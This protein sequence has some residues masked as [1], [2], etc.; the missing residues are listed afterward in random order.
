MKNKGFTLTELIVT[1]VIGSIII[2]AIT[3]QF[4]AEYR[5]RRAIEERGDSSREA[6]IAMNHMARVLRFV[7]PGTISITQSTD[8]PPDT[9]KIEATI[10]GDT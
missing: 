4:V 7:V 2:L 1:M 10:E 3:V 8:S 5:F 9:E 6:R